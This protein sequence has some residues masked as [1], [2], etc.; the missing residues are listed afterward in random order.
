MNYRGKPL[1]QIFFAKIVFFLNT[2]LKIDTLH[3]TIEAQAQ[4]V[5]NSINNNDSI[6]QISQD[7][8]KAKNH[9]RYNSQTQMN[10][11]KKQNAFNNQYNTTDKKCSNCGYSWHK[12]K[13]QCPARGIMRSIFNLNIQ[14]FC[15]TNLN[16]QATHAKQVKQNMIHNK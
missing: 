3:D 5:E 6:R 4:I 7:D 8:S 14:L 11:N 15:L 1:K 16:F 2:A 9:M 10:K 12:E 13:T